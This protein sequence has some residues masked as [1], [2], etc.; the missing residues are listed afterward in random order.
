MEAAAGALRKKTCRELFQLL[1]ST[2]LNCNRLRLMPHA[3]DA[4]IRKLR[5]L[6][7]GRL[8]AAAGSAPPTRPKRA[9]KNPSPEEAADEAMEEAIAVANDAIQDDDDAAEAEH[10]GSG[11][12][13]DAPG[14]I[15]GPVTSNVLAELQVRNLA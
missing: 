2:C 12:D 14:S 8:A 10:A 5:L 15:E 6:L 9:R 3:R 13:A 4:H 11:G 7:G 1:K